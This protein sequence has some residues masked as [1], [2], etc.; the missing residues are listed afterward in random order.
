ME[1]IVEVKLAGTPSSSGVLMG[2]AI[3]SHVKDEAGVPQEYFDL[4]G[5]H[6]TDEAVFQAAL[7]FAQ[8]DRKALVQ[9]AGMPVGSI[10]F[11]FPLTREAAKALGIEADRYGLVIGMRFD[12]P[13]AC[14]KLIGS[15]AFTGFSIG[16][17]ALESEEVQ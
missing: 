13:K 7:D 8:S 17:R 11:M 4:H 6:I 14:E 1:K 12:D 3:V 2:Y 16:Y 10:D 9:H 15:K 5:D